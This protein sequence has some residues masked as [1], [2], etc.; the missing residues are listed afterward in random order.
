MKSQSTSEQNN[1]PA[2]IRE[3]TRQ[4][5]RFVAEYI[6]DF[7]ATQAAIRADYSENTAAEQ[8]SR[9]LTHVKIQAEISE[10]LRD[11]ELRTQ[12]TADN[13]LIGLY[14]T[15]SYDIA[16][17]YNPDGTLKNIHD[18]PKEVRQAIVGIEVFEEFAG[19]GDDRVKIGET[20]K[21]KFGDKTKSQELLAKHLQLLI[22]RL[23][24]RFIKSIDDLTAEEQTALL[25]DL[26]KR[27]AE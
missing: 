26:R 24:V 23:D 16:D 20:K 21:V 27:L 25:E 12:I 18:I 4:Q 5:K 6:K 1:S 2:R 3:I 13:V 11:Q 22:D 9:L 19:R 17:A 14:K 8:G 10:A 7:N 15:A